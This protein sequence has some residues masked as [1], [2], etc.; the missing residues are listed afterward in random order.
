MIDLRRINEGARWYRADGSCGRAHL[1]ADEDHP[2]GI[3][4]D[5]KGPF[6]D[7]DPDGCG[8]GPVGYHFDPSD[9]DYD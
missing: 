6:A 4:I 9:D 7:P 8:Y 3:L 1:H 2:E 5:G